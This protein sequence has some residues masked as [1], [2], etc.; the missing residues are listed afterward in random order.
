MK[1]SEESKVRALPWTC[2]GSVDPLTP[3]LKAT[4]SRGF[5]PGGVQGQS[6]CRGS[7]QRP[8]KTKP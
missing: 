3:L 8:D 1:R 5:A 7:G 6:P 2:K 4:G